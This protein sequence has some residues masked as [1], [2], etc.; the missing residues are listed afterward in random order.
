MPKGNYRIVDVRLAPVQPHRPLA[1]RVQSVG[2]VIASRGRIRTASGRVTDDDG[3][4][5]AWGSLIA[6]VEAPLLP[7]ATSEISSRMGLNRLYLESPVP[8]DAP[9]RL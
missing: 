9:P 4:L 7:A 2:E 1:G 6:I 5:R 3:G 8:A